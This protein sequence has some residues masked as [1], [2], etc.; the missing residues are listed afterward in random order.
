[1]K[2]LYKINWSVKHNYI[3]VRMPGEMRAALN[4]LLTPLH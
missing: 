2:N 4:N 1:M 3:I